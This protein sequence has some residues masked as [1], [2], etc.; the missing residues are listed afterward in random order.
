MN[1]PEGEVPYETFNRRFD[2]L[3]GEDCRDLHGRLHYVRQGKHGMGLVVSY[4]SKI[5]WTDFPLDLVELKLQRLIAELQH[6]QYVP[7]CSSPIDINELL[8]VWTYLAQHAHSPSPQS[9]KMPP[10]LRRLNFPSSAKPS[11][12]STPGIPAKLTGMTVTRPLLM[13]A[14]LPLL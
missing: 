13:G 7:T 4:L 2:V 6:L 1:S 9:S 3:F 14:T 8:D 11:M 12:I 10:I 5:D